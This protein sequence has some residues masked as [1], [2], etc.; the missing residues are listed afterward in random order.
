MIKP[1]VLQFVAKKN[2]QI[3]TKISFGNKHITNNIVPNF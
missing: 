1:T 2:Q 3:A